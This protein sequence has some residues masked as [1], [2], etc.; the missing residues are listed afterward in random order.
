M[1]SNFASAISGGAPDNTT[2]DEGT[3]LTSVLETPTLR[4][5]LAL[6]IL[7]CID[8]MRSDLVATFDPDKTHSKTA[9]A[10]NA[11]AT[12]PPRRSAPTRAARAAQTA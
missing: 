1:F 5:E 9:A 11:T 10:A 4:V 6:L 3:S 8:D 2:K 12:P 7:L